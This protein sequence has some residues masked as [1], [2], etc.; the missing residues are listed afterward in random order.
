MSNF[1]FVFSLLVI[2]LS[3]ALAEV[4][5]GLAR[6]TKRRKVAIGCLTVLV[7]ID[8]LDPIESVLVPNWLELSAP[9][10]R[11]RLRLLGRRGGR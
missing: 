5:G 2:L 1:E 3:L 11:R 10:L 4:L 9:P 7:V 8:L 6:V